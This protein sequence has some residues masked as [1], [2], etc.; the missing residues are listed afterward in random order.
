[1]VYG[2]KVKLSYYY[3]L[4]LLQF[5]AYTFYWNELK[6]K[7]SNVKWKKTMTSSILAIFSQ[8]CDIL[9]SLEEKNLASEIMPCPQFS[10]SI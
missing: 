4:L 7:L 9:S 5:Y 6:Y 2:R 1:M 10:C 3:N 8:S